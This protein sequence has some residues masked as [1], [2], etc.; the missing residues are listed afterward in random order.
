MDHQPRAQHAATLVA[1]EYEEE[2]AKLSF[3]AE[4]PNA[5]EPSN[6]LGEPADFKKG[7]AEK[8]LAE[9]RYKVDRIYRTPLHNHNAIELHATTAQWSDDEER[10]TVYD[11]TQYVIGIQQMLAKKF[12]L[13]LENVRVLAPFVGGGFGGKGNAWAHVSLAVAAAKVAK[14]PVKL[15][16]SR[17]EVHRTVGGRT[18]SEQRVALAANNAG[19]FVSLI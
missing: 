5:V 18:P 19:Q 10:L 17:E 16:L 3:Q 11:A 4:K 2:A 7:D 1:V 6:I 13:K 9:A 8:A 15:V 14:R 12:S